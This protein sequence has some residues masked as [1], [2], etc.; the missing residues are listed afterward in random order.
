MIE[1]PT[2]ALVGLRAVLM[3]PFLERKGFLL[4][5]ASLRDPGG[6]V[7]GIEN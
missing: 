6:F 2:A 3:A 4:V 7:A 1:A 5:T